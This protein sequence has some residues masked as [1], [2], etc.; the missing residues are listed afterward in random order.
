MNN[1]N[2]N[3]IKRIWEGRENIPVIYRKEKSSLRAGFPYRP[4]NRLWLKEGHRNKPI[5]NKQ[6]RYWSMPASWFDD[7]VNKTLER[8]KNVY[9][10][11]PYRIQ[12]KCAP[13]CWNAKGHECNCSC[14]GAQHGSKSAGNAWFIVSDAFATKWTESEL[15]CRLIEKKV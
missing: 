15:A 2:L 1:E 5:W 6:E 11:Q 7:L 8:Y 9:V 4:D 13:A 12:E 10:I 3:K 14:M